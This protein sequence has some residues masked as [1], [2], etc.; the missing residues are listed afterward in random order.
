M[1]EIIY[2]QVTRGEMLMQTNIFEDI[3]NTP[4]LNELFWNSNQYASHIEYVYYM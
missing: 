1:E 4:K 2:N 3:F